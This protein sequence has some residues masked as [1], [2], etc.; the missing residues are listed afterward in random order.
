MTNS[1]RYDWRVARP[2]IQQRMAELRLS[3]ADLARASGLS[4]KHVR[5]LLNGDDM[6]VPRDQTLWALCD[7]LRWTP[8]SIDRI[9]AG[10]EPTEAEDVTGEVS[11][12]ELFARRIG[13]MEER[14]DEN[15]SA[16][17][18]VSDEQMKLY[19]QQKRHEGAVADA[20]A[21]LREDLAEVETGAALVAAELRERLAQLEKVVSDLRRAGPPADAES[22]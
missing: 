14:G 12:T 13:Q 1:H 9:L 19:R 10:G 18:A 3:A 17:A 5:R 21:D 11:L 16:I 2:R 7:A 15:R 6:T 8:H 22:P 20:L 4:D